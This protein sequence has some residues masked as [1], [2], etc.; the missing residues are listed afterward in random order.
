MNE[1]GID[2][3]RINAFEPKTVKNIYKTVVFNGFVDKIVK[4]R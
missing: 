3:F 4:I 2:F 1:A